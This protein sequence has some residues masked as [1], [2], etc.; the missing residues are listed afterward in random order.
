MRRYL[1]IFAL[2][3]G[4]GSLSAQVAISNGASLSNGAALIPGNPCVILTNSLPPGASGVLYDQSIL[5]ASCLQPFVYSV[6]T[7]T[8]PPWATFNPATGRISGIAAPGD[9]NFVIKLVDGSGGAFFTQA[10]TIS[11]PN[12]GGGGG[13]GSSPLLPSDDVLLWDTSVATGTPASGPELCIGT[14]TNPA[15][16]PHGGCSAT[17]TIGQINSVL[18]ST[19]VCGNIVVVQKDAFFDQTTGV[20]NGVGIPL[21]DCPNNNWLIVERD[22]TDANFPAEGQRVDPSY[23]G[24]PQSAAPNIPYPTANPTPNNTVRRMPRI[25]QKAT[26]NAAPI[27]VVLG[28]GNGT[29]S[30]QRWVGFELAR[31]A[32]ADA[33]TVGGI[34]LTYQPSSAGQPCEVTLNGSGVV[35]KNSLPVRAVSCMNVQPHDLVFDRFYIHGDVQRQTVR[36]INFAGARKVAFIDSW[37]SE[38]QVT[39]AGGQGDAQFYFAGGGHGYTNVGLYQI[40]NNET[41]SSSEGSIFCG[42]FT[43]ALSPA[44]G[45]DGVPHDVH[46]AKN[47]IIKNPLWNPM[48]GQTMAGATPPETSQVIDGIT[49][50]AAPDTTFDLNPSA[51]TLQVNQSYPVNSIW[52]NDTFGGFNRA[53]V[54]VSTIKVDGVVGGNST[55]GTLVRA[56]EH[57]VGSGAQVSN[58]QVTYTYTA[59]AVAGTHTVTI[60]VSTKD[61]RFSTLGNNRTLTGT[62]TVTVVAGTPTKSLIVTPNAASLRIQPSYPNATPGA[63]DAAGNSRQFCYQFYVVGNYTLGTL[64]YKVDTTVNGSSTIGTITQ[65]T[66]IGPGGF[67]Y[68]SADS[69]HQGNHS[70]TVTDTTNTITSPASVIS[71]S[72]TAPILGYD[73]KPENVKNAFECKCGEKILVENNYFENCWGSDGTGGGQTCPGVLLQTVN[74]ANQLNDG[75]GLPVGY[76]PGHVSNAT[77]RNNYW[78]H[79]GA[80]FIFVALNAAL[81]MHNVAFTGN[82]CD[83]CNYQR[84]GNGFLNIVEAIQTGGAGGTTRLGWTSPSNPLA[85]H[86]NFSHNSVFGAFTNTFSINNNNAQF[87]LCDFTFRDNIIASGGTTGTFINANGEANDCNIGNSEVKALVPCFVPYI[88]DHNELLD[89]TTS[90]ANF[91][92]SPVWLLDHT[93]AKFVNYNNSNGGDYRLCTTTLCGS[94]SPFASGQVDQASDGT[95]LGADVVGLGTVVQNALSGSRAGLPFS[96][97]TTSLPDATHGVAYSQT[98][99]VTG[100]VAPITW[101]TPAAVAPLGAQDIFDYAMMPANMRGTSH[102]SATGLYKA[103]RLDAGVF[104]WEKNTQGYP[105]DIEAYDDKEVYQWGTEMDSS[106]DAACIAGGWPSCFSDPQAFKMYPVP[107]PLWKR[108]HKPGEDDV[109]YTPGPNKYNST[110]N[111]G[112]DNQAQ[113]DNLG[114]RGELTGPFTDITWKTTYGGD[115]PD[116]TPYLLGQK[117]TKCTSNNIL[118]CTTEEDYWLVYKY[119]QARWCPKS[120]SGGV[121]VTGTCTTQ[122]TVSAGGAPTPNFACTLPNVPLS[123]GLP[124]GT[125]QT[126]EP[127]MN[128][129]DSTGEIKGTPLAAGTSTFTVQAEDAAGH[130]ATQTLSI[131]VH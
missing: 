52:L 117:W 115:I 49:Y 84:N 9:Y 18:T 89:S 1:L 122:T 28:A 61:S 26:N 54:A 67:L 73:Q 60:A 123:N 50:P 128:L 113:I 66:G 24:L 39:T 90:P 48:L 34:D 100:G 118:N 40:L 72:S 80:G 102:L 55:T 86:V 59:P 81:G 33:T 99:A 68:C 85:C 65:P 71:V 112:A 114:V 62:M 41:S 8:F 101:S 21:L 4:C 130:I 121:Y 92:S 53:G 124:A 93:A 7:G 103:Y 10:L 76:G 129:V 88:F 14:I 46:I 37:G 22:P 64:Q 79:M 17:F 69:A 104:F 23:A 3:T 36:G 109:V 57:S 75:N 108:Y 44:T 97:T 91:I 82:V 35:D 94:N 87:Q 95:D 20:N 32:S 63:V 111:C 116:H 30:H 98:L 12:A 42:A 127:S 27:A 56:T 131:V 6:F 13:G 25:L 2:L 31:D 16:L 110:T 83:D 58:N 74:Q 105:S 43:E 70:I 19:A 29:A 78:R 125:L 47:V 51:I 38:I 106:Q 45:F 5:T 107:V 96:I 11:T 120:L 119:G 15:A 77:F 126:S